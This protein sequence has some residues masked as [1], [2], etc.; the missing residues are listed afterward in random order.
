VD[1]ALETPFLLLGTHDQI[2]AQIVAA[3]ERWGISYFTVR[4]LDAFAPVIERLVG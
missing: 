4:E 2:A 3:R 1:D